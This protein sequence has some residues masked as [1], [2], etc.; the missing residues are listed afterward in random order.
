MTSDEP[1]RWEVGETVKKETV[2][3]PPSPEGKL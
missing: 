2:A 3:R 1:L